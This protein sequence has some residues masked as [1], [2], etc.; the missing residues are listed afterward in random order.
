MSRIIER[1]RPH[2]IRGKLAWWFTAAIVLAVSLVFVLMLVQQQR[3]IRSEWSDGLR[4][5]AR[6]I[7]TNS[8]AA[9]DF[10]DRQE[11]ARLLQAVQSTPS[12]LRA[13]L[14]V[15]GKTQPFAEFARTDDAP[16]SLPAPLR[17][18][19]DAHFGS[20][21]VVVWAPIPG[22]DGQAH[23]EL[24]ATLQEMRHVLWRTALETGAGL[25]ALLLAFLWLSSRA[26]RRLA[27]PL[28]S[29]N[30]LMARVADNPGLS[31]R[32]ATRG[33]DE[34]AQLGRSLNQMIDK[35]QTRDQELAQYR[36][37]LEQLV[38][39]RTHALLA[40]TE[41]AQQASRAKSDFLARMS[42]EIRTPM[43]AIV[44]LGQLLLRTELTAHQRDYQEQVIAASDMLLAL[45]NDI[46][47]YSRIEAGKLQIEAITFDLE[48]VLRGVSSQL[49]LH[50]RQKGLELLF[51]TNADV[52]RR[53]RG[54]PLRLSQ[55]LVNL[56]NNAVKF[57]AFGKIV[58]H[59][60]VQQRHGEHVQ[61]EFSVRDTGMGIPEERLAQLFTPFTQV[62]GS[63][64]RRFGGSGLGLAICRQ[65]VEL[66]GGSIAAQSRVGAGSRFY[67]T[68]PLA[69]AEPEP[70]PT[71]TDRQNG[72]AAR[73]HS[74]LR[75]GPRPDFSGIAH[76]RVL[77]VDD[78]ELNRT[79]ALAFLADTGVQVDVAVH[80]REAL[81]KVLGAP[82]DLVLMDIQMPEMDGLTATREIRKQ[83][84]L[85]GL[86]I[87]AMTAHAMV[88]DRERSLQAGMQDHLTKPLAPDALY[89]ALL[90][91]IAP[92]QAG[93][94]AATAAPT[95]TL[96]IPALAGMDTERGLAQ[97]L[98]RPELYQR[99]LANFVQEFAGSIQAM[100]DAQAARDWPLARR[101]AHSLKSASATIGATALA[102][103]AKGLE[104]SFMQ[105]HAATDEQLAS[106]RAELA[107][108]CALLTPWITATPATAPHGSTSVDDLAPLFQHLQT[109]LEND[110]AAALRVL[111]EL[112]AHTS[113]HPALHAALPRLRELVED[114]EYESALEQ[115]ASL[116]AQLEQAPA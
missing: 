99:L 81:D 16:A 67:F 108:V 49:G 1:L 25:S 4:A 14:L 50:A 93:R 82:Y 86:P 85:H 56:C 100:A 8:Q 40:A 78:V 65:L 26:A 64:T 114:I 105:R 18:G 69:L 2:S 11:A 34:L 13:R 68:L 60:R 76:A 6:L 30:Q 88:G 5:Q 75:Q 9:L 58:V 12:V 27:V 51:R 20:D 73:G 66:M 98:G 83:P 45:I 104:D 106:S 77:L 41:Q 90:R 37:N 10:R 62:D 48:Q 92:R 33:A 87:I 102:Q 95:P 54:D 70:E 116:R 32:V 96:G 72:A 46:L 44:G 38:E 19:Q 21:L 52:P 7:A 110:D 43:N 55:I 84:H 115:L 39:Q 53:L 89:A 71:R 28:Q 109:R 23:I 17:D 57:T 97:A 36:Q 35:L 91:W 112:Q 22:S 29:L 42:H 31:E 59:T 79:V 3:L 113:V 63:I 111:Q 103:Q 94:M 74:R 24:V 61:L 15:A 80:G 47:D 101:L 107:R